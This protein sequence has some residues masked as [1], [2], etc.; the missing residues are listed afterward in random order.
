M[1]H[2][3]DCGAYDQVYYQSLRVNFVNFEAEEMILLLFL[4]VYLPF[5]GIIFWRREKGEGM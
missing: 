4:R 3:E 1:S 5:A 2:T